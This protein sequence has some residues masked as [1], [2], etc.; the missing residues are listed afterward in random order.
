MPDPLPAGA[1]SRMGI[2][3]SKPD[4]LLVCAPQSAATTTAIVAAAVAVAVAV[5]ARA[6]QA[7]R[8]STNCH[9]CRADCRLPC[10]GRMCGDRCSETRAPLCTYHQ[11][12]TEDAVG[13]ALRLRCDHAL[14]VVATRRCWRGCGGYLT[15]DL[16]D[17][18]VGL[19]A[20]RGCPP[21]ESSVHPQ[22]PLRFRK[23]VSLF[24]GAV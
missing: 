22:A 4:H 21:L 15:M 6:R 3:R 8:V 2:G 10:P 5:S 13:D 1:G 23:I 20:R 17:G 11:G 12:A 16:G 19:A 7:S 24:A 18:L 14:I 9:G